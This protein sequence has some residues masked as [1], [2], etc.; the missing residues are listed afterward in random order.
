[1]MLWRE[2]ITGSTVHQGPPRG[3]LAQ[4]RWKW[5]CVNGQY[6]GKEVSAM[7]LINAT[8]RTQALG[9]FIKVDLPVLKIS[10]QV[11][12]DIFLRSQEIRKFERLK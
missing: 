1:M 8:S 11:L 6:E 10:N 9:P 7:L 2:L 3:R 4:N 12:V 5:A